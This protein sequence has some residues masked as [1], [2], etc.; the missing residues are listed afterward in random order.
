MSFNIKELLKNFQTLFEEFQTFSEEFQP[1]QRYDYKNKFLNTTDILNNFQK[2]IEQFETKKSYQNNE[3]YQQLIQNF[4]IVKENFNT[5][6]LIQEQ[7]KQFNYKIE[8]DENELYFFTID[9]N[10]LY[11]S[12]FSLTEKHQK[13]FKKISFS[14]IKFSFQLKNIL[15]NNVN[16]TDIPDH[17]LNPLLNTYKELES[18]YNPLYSIVPP[19]IYNNIPI[20]NFEFFKDFHCFQHYYDNAFKELERLERQEVLSSEPMVSF[21]KQAKILE[22]K[23]E[24]IYNPQNIID[25][26]LNGHSYVRFIIKRDHDN[27]SLYLEMKNTSRS[28]PPFKPKTI[29]VP[30]IKNGT[31]EDYLQLEE[32][33]H[34]KVEKTD[35]KRIFLNINDSIH[36]LNESK[37]SSVIHNLPEKTSMQQIKKDYYTIIEYLNLHYKREPSSYVAYLNFIPSQ[38]KFIIEE[39]N[40][41]NVFNK[42]NIIFYINNQFDPNFDFYKHLKFK[43][44][45]IDTQFIL[46]FM[47][48]HNDINNF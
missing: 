20:Q 37:V 13:D 9:T 45:G 14:L 23:L 36:S 28:I 31:I 42:T 47:K 33:K 41:V 40:Y 21:K 26:I 46:E 10:T 32:F 5:L 18:K 12:E 48:L 24:Q 15:K 44:N 6:E 25:N 38:N 11:E 30:H 1:M 3:Y 19:I 8:F 7:I 29:Y 43:N 34:L 17:I 27:S 16:A 22:T 35:S 4:S 39:S 2:L